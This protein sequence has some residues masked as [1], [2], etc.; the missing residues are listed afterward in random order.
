MCPLKSDEKKGHLYMNC[1][2]IYYNI[3][4]NYS[5]LY[6]ACL[7][8]RATVHLL[9]TLQM[10]DWSVQGYRDVRNCKIQL[11]TKRETCSS[12]GHHL[13]CVLSAVLVDF[14]GVV[15]LCAVPFSY[16]NLKG[17]AVP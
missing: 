5:S 9:Y 3:S 11:T 13:S 1:M 16:V 14:A 8:I 4:L 15:L 7:Y 12:E 10:R 2:H 17:K 6:G